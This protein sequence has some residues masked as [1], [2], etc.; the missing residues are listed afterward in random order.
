LSKSILDLQIRGLVAKFFHE[1]CGILTPNQCASSL[2]DILILLLQDADIKVRR[3]IV[4]HLDIIL[5]CFDIEDK[6]ARKLQYQ[7]FLPAIAACSKDGSN[8][9]RLHHTLL[10]HYIQFPKY[11]NH[12]TLV[13]L[14]VPQLIKMMDG[15]GQQILH[16]CCRVIAMFG[17][18]C[19]ET[20]CHEE[21][22]R[23]YENQYSCAESYT[24]R[25]VYLIACEVMFKTHSVRF[26]RERLLLTVVTLLDDLVL[27]IR[28]KALMLIPLLWHIL[29]AKE[30]K[31]I[32]RN[33]L[34]RLDI[35]ASA[36]K[37]ALLAQTAVQVKFVVEKLM[38]SSGG[39][40]NGNGNGGSGTTM[41]GEDSNIVRK[42][43]DQMLE[44]QEIA[45]G[46][47]KTQEV[48]DSRKQIINRLVASNKALR[49]AQSKGIIS[50]SSDEEDVLS[51]VRTSKLS[52]KKFKK[53]N[54]IIKGTSSNGG[55]GGTSNGRKKP[56]VLP[57]SKLPVIL[58]SEKGT[59]EAEVMAS[60]SSSSSNGGSGRAKPKRRGPPGKSRKGPPSPRTKKFGGTK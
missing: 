55:T 39:S 3:Q 49:K 58:G 52:S 35:E 45:L 37:Q 2:R 50:V 54:E 12:A 41:G 7:D 16:S 1:I 13:R 32:Q 48:S 53:K 51:V 44:E 47:Y 38:D 36:T 43:R 18:N 14:L 34:E 22:M 40:S 11:F 20:R 56:A 23:R 25:R 5:G 57:R 15:S 59:R 27:D 4:Q 21:M 17:R 26:G 46:V 31:A 8:E 33:L 10:G 19:P 42:K 24:K 9:W 60:S 6:E 30:D 28:R 29:I